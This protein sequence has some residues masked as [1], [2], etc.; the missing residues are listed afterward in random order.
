MDIHLE[1][2]F[3]KHVRSVVTAQSHPEESRLPSVKDTEAE[4]NPG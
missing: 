4:C 1:Y 3:K 2:E